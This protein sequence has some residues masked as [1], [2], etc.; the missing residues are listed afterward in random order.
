MSSNV[1]I[2]RKYIILKPD[3]EI[4]CK[5]EGYESSDIVQT[6]LT[7]DEGMTRR[8]RKRVYSD[9]TVYTET[10]KRRIDKLSSYEDE[11]DISEEE[12]E[13]LLSEI[14]KGTHHVIKT[15]RVIR[16]FGIDFEI[17]EYPEWKHTCIMETELASRD[18]SV[19]FPDC[20]KVLLEVTGDKKYS[21]AAMSR[22]FPQEII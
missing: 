9:R 10:V 13:A 12:Y 20:I 11:R 1:E 7:S 15:R 14:A 17:D 4:L 18:V 21:N 5:Y 6:Y 22:S 2:E 8:V 19:T 16:C 3:P